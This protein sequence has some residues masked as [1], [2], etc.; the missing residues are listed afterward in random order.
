MDFVTPVASRVA[1]VPVDVGSRVVAGETLV[2]LEVMK[3]EHVVV[4]REAGVVTAIKVSEGD[5][6]EVGDPLISFEPSEAGD[7]MVPTEH[8]E[9][10]SALEEVEERHRLTLDEARPEAVEARHGRGR[11][12]VR[13]NLADLCPEF[14]EYGPLTVAAQRSRRDLDDLIRRTPADGMVGGVGRVGTLTGGDDRAIIISYDYTVLAGTQGAYNHHKKT[15][16]SGWPP[17]PACPLFSSPRVVAVV[18]AMST[19]TGR[20]CWT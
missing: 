18:P 5:S 8:P 4:S 16:C 14:V 17:T 1:R 3:M 10:L 20:P 15:G 7:S 2:V 13:E 6:V 19:G 12:T 11:R 9:D